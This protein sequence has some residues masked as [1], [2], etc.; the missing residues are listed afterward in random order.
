MEKESAGKA[1]IL[2]Q[3]TILAWIDELI[4]K[5]NTSEPPSLVF[6]E[7]ICAGRIWVSKAPDNF[8]A[9]CLK[10]LSQRTE[11]SFNP[12]DL[13]LAGLAAP[14]FGEDFSLL[15]QLSNNHLR[16]SKLLDP[17]ETGLLQWP[18]STPQYWPAVQAAWISS[19]DQLLKHK[20]P[21]SQME[22]VIQLKEIYVYETDHQLWQKSKNTYQVLPTATATEIL[23]VANNALAM[24]AWIPDQD[25][26]EDILSSLRKSAAPWQNKEQAIN[27]WLGPAAYLLFEAL[28]AYEMTQAAQEL[29]NYVNNHL[30]TTPDNAMQKCLYQLWEESTN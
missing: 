21:P 1:G 5:N 19:S 8:K 23:T 29:S 9:F 16:L 27:E 6:A 22:Q 15:E 17:N 7:W 14:L 28:K 24:L 12:S 30:S 26:A 18:S 2:K 25:R 20:L 3:E 11:T 4:Q 10:Q 13:V